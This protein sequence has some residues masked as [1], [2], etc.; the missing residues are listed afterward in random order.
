M[1]EFIILIAIKWIRC[2][3]RS[4]HILLRESTPLLLIEN[5]TLSFIATLRTRSS[6]TCATSSDFDCRYHGS[7]GSGLLETKDYHPVEKWIEWSA[8]P[9][10][11][12]SSSAKRFNWDKRTEASARRSRAIPLVPKLL[13]GLTLFSTLW[14]H[15]LNNLAEHLIVEEVGPSMGSLIWFRSLG[16]TES[17]CLLMTYKAQRPV[18][19]R[20]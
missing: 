6:F 7:E 5:T 2:Y 19:L 1:T 15:F 11:M 12:N 10:Y 9:I 8:C 14:I 20:F 13:Q 18:Y 3:G 4:V 16:F 17:L